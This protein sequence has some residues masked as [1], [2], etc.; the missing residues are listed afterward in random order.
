M[1]IYKTKEKRDGLSKYRVRINYI[2][3]SGK[4]R[5]LTRI[6]Y[7]LAAAKELEAKLS[8]NKNEQVHSNMMLQ[9][10]IELYFES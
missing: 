1:P 10:L 5:S 6:A 3:D 2:D 4:N 8:R 7:G 9:D